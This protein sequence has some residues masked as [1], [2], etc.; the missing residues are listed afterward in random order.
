MTLSAAFVPAYNCERVQGGKITLTRKALSGLEQFAS[1]WPGEI[2]LF[3]KTV[4]AS[5]TRKDLDFIEV[6]PQDLPCQVTLR[7]DDSQLEAKALGQFD[8]IYLTPNYKAVHSSVCRS[9]APFVYL[10]ENPLPTRLQMLKETQ[11]NPIGYAF[12]SWREARYEKYLLKHFMAAK[13]IQC[14][15]TPAYEAY[16]SLTPNPLLFFDG[17]IDRSHVV[18]GEE[19]AKRLDRLKTPSHTLQ[20]A[21]SGRL[22]EIKGVSFLPE[23]GAALRGLGVPFSMKIFGDGPLG[24][25]VAASISSL[26]LSEQLKLMGT[27]DFEDA[28]LPQLSTETD[29]FVCCHLQG[30]PSCTYLETLACGVPIVGFS[31]TALEGMAELSPALHGTPIGDAQALA[32]RI[33]HLYRDRDLI[34]SSSQAAREFA[35]KHTMEATFKARAQHLVECAESAKR[36]GV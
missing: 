8:L 13:G 3:L 5:N 12:R 31:N 33:A 30:D 7:Q 2:T 32:Q 21:F 1:H 28:L 29:L 19:L 16:R 14:N 9:Q 15:G 25:E 4:P 10:A 36:E 6:A 34:R 22:I 11:R 18:G 27:V 20:L 24:K 23:V 17:R 26:G 35:L